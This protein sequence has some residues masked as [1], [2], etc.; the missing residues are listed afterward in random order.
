MRRE[1]GVVRE[2]SHESFAPLYDFVDDGERLCLVMQLIN[3]GDVAG[4][5]AEELARHVDALQAVEGLLVV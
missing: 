4:A 1:V 2:L 5:V 3:G